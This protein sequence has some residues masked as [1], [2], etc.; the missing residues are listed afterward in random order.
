M[1]SHLLNIHWINEIKEKY[2][3]N[4]E[5]WFDEMNKEDY[6][7][8]SRFNCCETICTIGYYIQTGIDI[9]RVSSDFVSKLWDLISDIPSQK[10]YLNMCPVLKGYE[11]VGIWN[12]GWFEL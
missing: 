11:A 2:T 1:S 5:L 3:I 12:S 4:A 9:Y 7:I 10:C 8:L 6:E